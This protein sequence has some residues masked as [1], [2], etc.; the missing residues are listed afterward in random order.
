[1]R[2]PFVVIGLG[3][4]GGS[5][6][7]E[8][9]RQG[10]EVLAIDRDD[11]KIEAFREHVTSSVVADATDEKVL[12]ELGVHEYTHVIVAIGNDIE[13]SILTTLLLSELGVP[14]ISVKAQNDYHARVLTKIGADRVL[15]PERDMGTRLAHNLMSKNIIDYAELSGQLSV[16]EMTVDE[17]K[18]G[19]TIGALE[20]RRKY[21]CAVVAVCRNGT[22]F[23]SPP[24]TEVIK[25]GDIL[26]VLGLTKDVYQLEQ[27]M[28]HKKEG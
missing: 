27:A 14:D 17:H 2:R 23:S 28:A 16:M 12:K 4:F 21:H 3:R 24:M 22:F 5:V 10:A 11:A 1:M 19:G 15:H 25:K 9:I 8:L 26:V 7:Q 18:C 6:T 20:L 13:A